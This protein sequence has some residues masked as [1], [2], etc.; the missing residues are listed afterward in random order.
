MA[1]PEAATLQ[2]IREEAGLQHIKMAATPTP[3][4]G[5]G[6][7]LD[8]YVD[9]KY[10]VDRTYDDVLDGTDV[11]VYVAGEA[12][13]V[14]SV[15]ADTGRVRMV[16]APANAATVRVDYAH[17]VLSDTGAGIVRSEATSWLRSKVNSYIDYD[18]LTEGTYPAIFSTVVKLYA[19]GLLLIRDYGSSADTNLSS[20]DGYEKIK[21]AKSMISDWITDTLDDED[22]IAPLSGSL[23]TDGNVFRRN[24]DLDGTLS[25]PYP[26]D[27]RFMHHDN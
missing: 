24:T 15:V 25:S 22:T 16:D 2:A 12:A 18:E 20:K 6:S 14:S 23:R 27:D 3:A 7:N 1:A 11:V 5:D 10:V 26:D 8:F 9:R 19:A 17:S 21:L 13:T 4:T